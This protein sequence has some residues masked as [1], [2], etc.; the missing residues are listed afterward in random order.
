MKSIHKSTLALLV[1]LF[2][3]TIAQS[4]ISQDYGSSPKRAVTEISFRVPFGPVFP[5]EFNGTLNDTTGVLES[6]TFRVPLNSFVGL[7]SGYL[8][9]IGNSWY[10]PD[11]E[12][13]SLQ[14]TP[15]ED[16][17]RVKGR[18]EFRGLESPV[19][20]RLQRTDMQDDNE[21]VFK[22]EFALQTHDYFTFAPPLDLVPSMIPMK[23]TMTIDNPIRS[24]I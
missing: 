20:L 19:T 14:I 23:I 8:E 5:I 15:E 21:I 18:L 11:M 2:V 17:Y 16:Q 9:W 1:I 13:R 24:G 3:F 12:F 4:G 6:V 22:G 10:Y 7:N